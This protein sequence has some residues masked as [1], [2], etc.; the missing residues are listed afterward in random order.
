ML[1]VSTTHTGFSDDIVTG[2]ELLEQLRE[3]LYHVTIRNTHVL[4]ANRSRY[5]LDN[6][7]VIVKGH[8]ILRSSKLFQNR[9]VS[10]NM[11]PILNDLAGQKQRRGTILDD[12]M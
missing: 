10:L 9:Y 11:C 6:T 7:K 2:A 3:V 12:T 1:R 4:S 8:I 5:K